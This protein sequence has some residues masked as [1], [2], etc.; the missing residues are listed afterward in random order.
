MAEPPDHL[1]RVAES[2]ELLR[3]LLAEWDEDNDPFTAEEWGRIDETFGRILRNY[4]RAKMFQRTKPSYI[5]D[6]VTGERVQVDAGGE[7][8]SD[9]EWA[10]GWLDWHGIGLSNAPRPGEAKPPDLAPAHR[11]VRRLPR[12]TD[13]LLEKV[14]LAHKAGVTGFKTL[15]AW[16][17]QTGVVL[18]QRTLQRRF[19][20]LARPGETPWICAV[21]H[22]EEAG[23]I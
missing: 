2:S 16:R 3:R 9:Q 20:P 10:Q 6:G 18:A 12:T 4:H 11:D 5:V 1:R 8:I 17:Q 23:L 15:T 14:A 21:R 7:R 19:G 22:A 13:D